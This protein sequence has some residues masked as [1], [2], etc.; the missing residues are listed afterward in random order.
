MNIIK[1]LLFCFIISL[2]LISN[3]KI[4]TTY[5]AKTSYYSKLNKVQKKAY[6]KIVDKLQKTKKNKHIPISF[7]SNIETILLSME[8]VF[9]DMPYFSSGS[10]ELDYTSD[11][12]T[13]KITIK[14]IN[15]KKTIRKIKNIVKNL[16]LGGND[17]IETLLNIHNYLI[18]KIEYDVKA[19]NGFDIRG[20]LIDGKAVCE[21]YAR[22]FK[23]LCDTYEIPCILVTGEA[24]STL[25]SSTE[26]HMWNCVKLDG[27]WYIVDVTWDDGYHLEPSAKYSFFLIGEKTL[28]GN[29][30]RFTDTHKKDKYFFNFATAI[31]NIKGFKY[32]KI[33]EDSYFEKQS[34]YE[35]LL[36]LGYIEPKPY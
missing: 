8:A 7:D 10:L 17:E 21:G 24:Q 3:I 2:F 32:P 36:E 23:Y 30:R 13:T 28:T 27:E 26:R 5:A 22:T 1:K 6:K 33:S 19:K 18:D 12:K 31:S 9:A 4:E 16:N 20:A 29:K 34:S 14:E 35:A 11:T 25:Y 15:N